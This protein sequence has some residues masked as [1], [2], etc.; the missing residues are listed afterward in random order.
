MKKSELWAV[1]EAVLSLLLET[2]QESGLEATL[3]DL[4][5]LARTV[6]WNEYWEGPTW[7]EMQVMRAEMFERTSPAQ[8]TGTIRRRIYAWWGSLD[9]ARRDALLQELLVLKRQKLSGGISPRIP[10]LWENVLT[11]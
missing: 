7:D 9:V 2:V 1:V 6:R 5:V 8:I 10:D 11:V 3:W 4:F